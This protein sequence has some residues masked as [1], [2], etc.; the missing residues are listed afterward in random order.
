MIHASAL[1]FLSQFSFSVGARDRGEDGFEVGLGLASISATQPEPKSE[2]PQVTSESPPIVPEKARVPIPVAPIFPEPI[3]EPE[4]NLQPV[5]NVVE[6]DAVEVPPNQASTTSSLGVSE[7]VNDVSLGRGL[8][9]SYGGSIGSQNLYVAK[10]AAR[11]NRFKYYPMKALRQREEGVVELS[12]VL[13]RNGRVLSMAVV[14][15]SGSRILDESALRIVQR[16]K[17]L[18]RFDRRMDMDQLKVRIPID[19]EIASNKHR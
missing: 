12:L 18:P 8:S 1:V 2:P 3:Q 7:V 9:S 19:F 16:A 10:L 15:S 14:G 5:Q 11:L 4:P 13:K 6:R 17:P